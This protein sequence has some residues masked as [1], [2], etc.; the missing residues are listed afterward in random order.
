MFT[1]IKKIE[2]AGSHHLCLPYESKC[3]N[4]H[5]HNWNI[6]VQVACHSLT[7]YGMVVDFGV[8]SSVVNRLDHQ[9]INEVVK[10]N[11][12]AEN[13]AKWIA[14]EV[15]ATIRKNFIQFYADEAVHNA[16]RS[17]INAL[18]T[19]TNETPEEITKRCEGKN[20]TPWNLLIEK[21]AQQLES[22]GKFPKV[23][24]VTIQESE[25][26]IAVYEPASWSFM[27]AGIHIAELSTDAK[28][29]GECKCIR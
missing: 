26:N 20:T 22:Q 25:G 19:M 6:E 29:E 28:C 17:V 13:I 9:S 1:V 16:D 18:Q 4:V 24:K 15:T 2:V 3:S 27:N 7:S 21:V 10:E 11:P 5:G 8:I 12:T 14:N 23:T